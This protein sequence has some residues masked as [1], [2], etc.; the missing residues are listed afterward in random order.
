MEKKQKY[1]KLKSLDQGVKTGKL[2]DQKIW[3][4]L[5]YKRT[6]CCVEWNIF[7]KLYLK[8]V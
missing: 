2:W 1:C 5:E 7:E 8:W 3:N 4:V 6:K